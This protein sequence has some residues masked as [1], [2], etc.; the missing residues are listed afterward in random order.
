MENIKRKEAYREEDAAR[1]RARHDVKMRI[2]L[3]ELQ[4]KKVASSPAPNSHTSMMYAPTNFP[5]YGSP[6]SSNL[7]LLS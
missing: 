4:Q 2:L 7:H 3:F 1:K 6:T 5:V